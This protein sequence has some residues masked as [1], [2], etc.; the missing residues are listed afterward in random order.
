MQFPVIGIYGHVNL[1]RRPVACEKS[2][3]VAL[4]FSREATVS[5]VCNA[6][7]QPKQGCNRKALT[8]TRS[9]NTINS[10]YLGNASSYSMINKYTKAVIG[11]RIFPI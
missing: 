1:K 7:Q 9:V 2:Y 8:F 11:Y 3:A 10:I 4:Q 5:Q 6:T